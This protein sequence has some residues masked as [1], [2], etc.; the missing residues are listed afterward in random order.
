[1][2][3]NVTNVFLSHCIDFISDLYRRLLTPVEALITTDTVTSLQDHHHHHLQQQQQQHND[4][5]DQSDTA[6]SIDDAAGQISDE[7]TASVIE[8]EVG[9]TDHWPSV[10]TASSL[11]SNHP[12]AS[13]DS[14]LL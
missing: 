14:V 3:L 9:R 6:S 7:E 12:A 1:M 5:T 10:N 13:D 2:K 8:V 11:P 4:V